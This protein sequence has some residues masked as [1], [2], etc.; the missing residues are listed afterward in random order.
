M[1]EALEKRGRKRR[2][3]VSRTDKNMRTRSSRKKIMK[4][5]K[6]KFTFDKKGLVFFFK[7]YLW[8][9]IIGLGI[10]VVLYP[11]VSQL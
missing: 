7:N 8:M 2:L 1:L 3:S 10:L 4:K 6:N 11:F 5:R 9:I